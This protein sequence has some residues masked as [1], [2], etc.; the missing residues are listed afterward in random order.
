MKKRREKLEEPSEFPSPIIFRMCGQMPEH[1]T[2]RDLW[3]AAVAR[4]QGSPGHLNS[5]KQR[6]CLPEPRGHA[7]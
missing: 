5:N 4:R 3:A 6:V 7:N 1:S 2:P